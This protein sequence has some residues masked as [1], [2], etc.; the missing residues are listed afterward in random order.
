MGSIAYRL[1]SIWKLFGQEKK[2]FDNFNYLT[3][4]LKVKSTTVHGEEI[5][6][7]AVKSKC[8][9]SIQK[10]YTPIIKYISPRVTYYESRTEV[11]FDPFN[12]PGLILNLDLDEM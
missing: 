2:T 9:I 10:Q 11:Y 5:L 4:Y 12:V 8:M 3:F 7:C 6:E 1:P